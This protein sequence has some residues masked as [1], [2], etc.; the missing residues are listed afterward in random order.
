MT[1]E[2]AQPKER[3]TIREA[4][5][6][7]RT[8]AKTSLTDQMAEIGMDPRQD[9]VGGDWR[10]CNFYGSD[11][12][13]CDFSRARLFD[14]DFTGVDVSDADFRT[15]SDV[16][17]TNLHK[18]RNWDKARLTSAQFS[19]VAANAGA[20]NPQRQLHNRLL[21]P[22]IEAT[23]LDAAEA[24]LEELIAEFPL[25]GWGYTA[26]INK[27]FGDDDRRRGIALFEEFVAKGGVVDVALATARLG[28][29][30]DFRSAVSFMDAMRREKI[31]P[32]E[33]AYNTLISMAPDFRTAM[34]QLREMDRHDV[35]PGKHTAFALF[36]TC[37]SFANAV[38]VLMHLHER[39][40][41]VFTSSF[42]WELCKSSRNPVET[43]TRARALREH[44]QS[45]RVVI[46]K[47]IRAYTMD[48]F[49]HDALTALDL[50]D[51]GLED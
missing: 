4:I 46:A 45:A 47:I 40:V 20:S 25:S 51:V 30:P 28:A 33:Q 9:F 19:L 44:N 26:A 38:T 7:L 1:G 15:A 18:A 37:E 5:D 13:G 39:R 49:R 24:A 42:L 3:L 6:T 21:Q 32:D 48:P 12:R 35:P 27:A 10:R 8:T 31:E 11:L 41:D 50:L 43:V 14:A 2:R 17:R 16:Y 34:R 36:D 22:I 29:S 23:H